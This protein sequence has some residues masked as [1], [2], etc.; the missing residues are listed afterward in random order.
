MNSPVEWTEDD[1]RFLEQFLASDTGHKLQLIVKQHEP[2]IAGSDFQAVALNAKMF[3][4]RRRDKNMINVL[5]TPNLQQ[6]PQVRGVNVAGLDV[7]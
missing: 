7:R 4:Q 1:R 5:L 3:E 6:K 2:I